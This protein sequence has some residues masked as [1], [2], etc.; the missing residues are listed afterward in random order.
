VVRE[1]DARVASL[2]LAVRDDMDEVVPQREA[3]R[4]PDVRDCGELNVRH[5]LEP[6]THRRL[7]GRPSLGE[8]RNS[9]IVVVGE[10]SVPQFRMLSAKPNAPAPFDVER[11]HERAAQV[12]NR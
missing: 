4:R 5:R 9:R 10:R 6:R 7:V 11:V 1:Q 8:G 12:A 2:R 3:V